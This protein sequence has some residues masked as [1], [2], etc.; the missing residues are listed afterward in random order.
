M[1]LANNHLNDFRT[2]A[3]EYD[4]QV[5]KQIGIKAFGYTYGTVDE[6]RPQ[7]SSCILTFFYIEILCTPAFDF[8]LL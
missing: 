6:D 7:V 8:R 3:V 2:R 5:L 4:L 1:T